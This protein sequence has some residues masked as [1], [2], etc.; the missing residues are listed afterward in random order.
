MKQKVTQDAPQEHLAPEPRAYDPVAEE[1]AHR[2]NEE[3]EHK[4]FDRERLDFFGT[5]VRPGGLV[6]DL[7]CGPGDSLQSR[8]ENQ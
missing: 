4:P 2:Y 8:R 1:Y 7:G 5:L 3:L 6:A